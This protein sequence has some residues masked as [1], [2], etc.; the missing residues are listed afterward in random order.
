L[1]GG[2]VSI[3]IIDFN[4]IVTQFVGITQLAMTVRGFHALQKHKTDSLFS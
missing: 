4:K 2:I 3:L 1:I